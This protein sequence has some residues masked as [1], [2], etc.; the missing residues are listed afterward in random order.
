MATEDHHQ[1]SFQQDSHS[2]SP[3]LAR[4]S[5]FHPYGQGG[6]G[7]HQYSRHQQIVP[8]TAVVTSGY[9][10][11]NPPA[12]YLNA[13]HTT[14]QNMYQE[15]RSPSFG[16]HGGASS[17]P[18]VAQRD[19]SKSQSPASHRGT[20]GS[21]MP[22]PSR[23]NKHVTRMAMPAT[24]PLEEN[25]QSSSSRWHRDTSKTRTTQRVAESSTPSPHPM[26][27]PYQNPYSPSQIDARP[28]GQS[29]HARDSA[30]ERRRSAALGV[31]DEVAGSEGSKGEENNKA[32]EEQYLSKTKGVER[33]KKTSTA[34]GNVSRG[35]TRTNADGELEWRATDHGD[36]GKVSPV[37]L[38]LC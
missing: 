16:S 12:A 22:G 24:Q 28:I 17:S 10:Y 23:N 36:G 38:R 8:Q 21:Q 9:T 18:S 4:H 33:A 37:R 25:A 34:K 29:V 35:L 6:S 2:N 1:R 11:P 20:V 5:G 26:S 14:A 31:D 19:I 3:G 32:S 27:V 30:R 13:S 15:I 7:L